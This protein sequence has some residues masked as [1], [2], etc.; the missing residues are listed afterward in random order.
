[1][2]G[3]AGVVAVE[4][5]IEGTVLEWMRSRECLH[6]GVACSLGAAERVRQSPGCGY[7]I[8]D[9]SLEKCEPWDGEW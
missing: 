4:E 3:C 2:S 6:A 1:M 7:P 8:A 9:W 5:Q